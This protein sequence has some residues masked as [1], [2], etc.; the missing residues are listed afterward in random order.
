[1][2]AFA[3]VAR[4][5][6]GLFLGA[7]SVVMKGLE[8]PETLEAVACREGLTLAANLLL[9]RLRVVTDCINVVRSIDGDG[10]GSYGHIVKEIRARS[11]DFREVNFVHEG[12]TSNVDAHNLARSSI[13]L[14][15]GGHVW[16][17]APPAVLASI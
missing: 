10:M 8:D 11:E 3:A 15:F 2:A 13:I 7:S 12:R 5:D 17:Q 9:Q 14:D 4:G 1:M 6:D 16:F